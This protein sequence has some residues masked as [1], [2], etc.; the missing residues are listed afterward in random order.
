M[1]DIFLSYA[2]EDRE[3]ALPIVDLLTHRGYSVWWD[4]KLVPGRNYGRQ[5]EEVLRRAECVVVLWTRDSVAS[6]FV[7]DEAR[8]GQE[9]LV[10]V[11]L[12]D[13]EP[14]V[15]FGRIQAADLRGWAGDVGHPGIQQLDAGIR[16]C[17]D[18]PPPP[19]PP[20]RRWVAWL[21]LLAPSL[22]AASI[23]L[24]VLQWPMTTTVEADVLATRLRFHTIAG[25]T[26]QLFD[27]MPAHSLAVR[28][29]ETVTLP[30]H[31][32]LRPSGTD[33]ARI[34]V[35][36]ADSRESLSMDGISAPST[37]VTMD[38]PEPG[39][40]GLTVRGSK[41]NAGVSL[42]SEIRLIATA[43]VSDAAVWRSDKP[44]AA[45]RLTVD[46]ADRLMEFS[47][48]AEPLRLVI[49]LIPDRNEQVLKPDV[50][51]DRVEFQEQGPTGQVKSTIQKGR[52][53]FPDRWRGDDLDVNDFL[54]LE[55]VRDFLIR[56]VELAGSTLRVRLYGRGRVSY[57]PARHL[58][59][60]PIRPILTGAVVFGWLLLTWLAWR[61][62]GRAIRL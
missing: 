46:P 36:P 10:P 33:P 39:S 62:F 47:S 2:R 5:I 18:T 26:Q 6:D 12:D 44:S 1:H 8:I 29:F 11:L 14:P 52:V 43:C 21:G 25:A 42:P 13:V 57:G 9:K 3:R 31:V 48:G 53:R 4:H 17:F 20:S 37:E 27:A 50:A 60:A 51:V 23:I 30:K 32:V 55:D 7:Q 35:V 40:I 34:S 28:G 19:R 61:R 22:I 15:G 59:R 56:R 24:A 58:K 54:L 41:V 49:G 16:A 38:V 45:L